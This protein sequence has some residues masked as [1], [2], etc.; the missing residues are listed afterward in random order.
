MTIRRRHCLFKRP[1][2]VNGYTRFLYNVS[3]AVTDQ[4]LE[5]LREGIFCHGG[6]VCIHSD[7]L[8]HM[9]NP[10]VHRTGISWILLLLPYG[11][12]WRQ[13]RKALHRF[14]DPTSVSQ[15]YATQER[16]SGILLKRLLEAPD[17]FI[18]HL[19][20]CVIRNRVEYSLLTG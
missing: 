20:L 2:T 7:L 17:A 8:G 4:V 5:L 19:H 13:G 18:E 1:R 3:G 9:I 14:F 11:S 10:L 12:A 15:F 6:A 16:H